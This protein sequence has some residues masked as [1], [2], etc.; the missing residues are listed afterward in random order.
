MKCQLYNGGVVSLNVSMM[1]LAEIR[2]SQRLIKLKANVSEQRPEA[3]TFDPPEAGK[4]PL[5]KHWRT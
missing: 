4:H 1:L 3:L 5:C 2:G